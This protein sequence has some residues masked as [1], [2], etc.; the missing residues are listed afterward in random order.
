MTTKH[1]CETHDPRGCEPCMQLEVELWN[2][3]NSYV[4]DRVLD[5][6]KETR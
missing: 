2:A 1:T 6:K 4:L 5:V 3:I